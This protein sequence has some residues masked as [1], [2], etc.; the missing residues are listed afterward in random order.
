MALLAL[1]LSPFFAL[2]LLLLLPLLQVEGKIPCEWTREAKL[3]K[4]DYLN[5]NASKILIG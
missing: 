5:N 4:K 3:L 1:A 2:A